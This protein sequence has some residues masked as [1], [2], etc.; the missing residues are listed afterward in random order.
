VFPQSSKHKQTG[1]SKGILC[2]IFIAHANWQLDE[3]CRN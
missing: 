2:C 3:K 1:V